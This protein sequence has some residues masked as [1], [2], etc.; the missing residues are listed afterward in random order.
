[1]FIFQIFSRTHSHELTTGE[2]I[3]GDSRE[4]KNF[5][6]GNLKMET[7]SVLAQSSKN[8]A[9]N[10]EGTDDL[11]SLEL[12]RTCKSTARVPVLIKPRTHVYL[13]DVWVDD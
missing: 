6:N 4:A 1:L 8:T 7:P 10:L 9:F 13:H 12:V 11:P 2:Q 3:H 5:E